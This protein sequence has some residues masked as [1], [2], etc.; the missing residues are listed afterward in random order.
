ME[1]VCCPSKGCFNKE[2]NPYSGY[3]C[4]ENYFKSPDIAI[5]ACPH[6]EEN[7]GVKQEFVFNKV[8]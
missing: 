6:Y 5:T 1:S 4:F 8:G 7:C 3:T 2:D